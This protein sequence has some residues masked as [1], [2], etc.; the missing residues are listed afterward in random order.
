M[1]RVLLLLV[2]IHTLYGDEILL[3]KALSDNLQ[4]IPSNKKELL[5]LIDD[6]KNKI[7]KNKIELGKKL[8][9]DPRLSK[10]NLISCN[11]CHNL[12]MGGVDG[13]SAAIGDNWHPNPLHLHSPTVYNAVFLTYQFWDGRSPDLADQAKGPMTAPFEMASNPN[14][15]A[16][17]IKSIKGYK[18]LF[19][20]AY[21]K[22]TPI[23][24]DLIAQ[25]IAIFEKT[26]ITPSR[27]DKFLQ[28]D[29]DAL[30]LQEKK[31]LDIFIDKRCTSCH[32]GIAIGGKM[33]YFVMKNFTYKDVGAFHGNDNK[34]VRVPTLRNISKTAPYFHNG[35]VWS[36]KDAV[37]EMARVQLKLTISDD[38][39]KSI[40]DFLHSLDGEMPNIIYPQLPR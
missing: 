40:V 19:A 32:H 16:Q 34:L 22:K 30:S 36:L 20:K 15:I 17:K 38:E 13:V 2:L 1:K 23:T 25:T 7:T 8:F 35:T 29:L 6:P 10:S 27:F 12:G 11:T 14:E 26:L 3:K 9:F 4:P 33:R 31:G 37:L 28:G 24:F 18:E 39:A 21:G 5:Q